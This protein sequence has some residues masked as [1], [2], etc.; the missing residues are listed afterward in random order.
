MLNALAAHA[1][2]GSLVAVHAVPIRLPEQ[3]DGVDALVLPGGES[4]TMGKV[5]TRWGLVRRDSVMVV[6]ADVT[7]SAA[8]AGGAAEE[9]GRCRPPDLGDVRRHDHACAVGQARGR[10][11]LAEEE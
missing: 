5:A 2:D 11:A 3:L 8:A 1:A 4:T 9:V 6:K 10:G 7:D